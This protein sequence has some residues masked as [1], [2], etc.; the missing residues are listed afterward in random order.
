[1]LGPSGRGA[2]VLVKKALSLGAMPATH[3]KARMGGVMRDTVR[4]RRQAQAS[5]RVSDSKTVESTSISSK[6][7]PFAGRRWTEIYGRSSN[8]REPPTP[9]DRKSV[10]RVLESSTSR[11]GARQARALRSGLSAHAVLRSER[12]SSS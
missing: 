3:A 4:A 7:S 10:T 9:L 5:K 6:V 11:R 2:A 12:G 8:R 1:M